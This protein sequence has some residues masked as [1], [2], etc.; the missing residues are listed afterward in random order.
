MQ[1]HGFIFLYFS[2]YDQL[3]GFKL[4]IGNLSRPW[5]Y[6]QEIPSNYTSDTIYVFK[7]N[8]AIASVISLTKVGT[9]LLICEVTVEGGR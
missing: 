8:D 6:K 2:D 5:I 1:L 4:Y 3:S 9:I 7:P